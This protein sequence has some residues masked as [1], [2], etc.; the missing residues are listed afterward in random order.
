M[1]VLEEFAKVGIDGVSIGSNDLTMLTLGVDRDNEKIAKD[2]NEM[3][4]AVL[5]MLEQTIKKCQKLKLTS[6]ICG[7]APSD[8]P[9]FAE[10]L[11][12]CGIDSISL[13]PD[14]VAKGCQQ[15][16]KAEKKRE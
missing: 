16:A 15:V 11:V 13:N 2:F 5:W 9:E 7:Q 1:V 10:F 3:D 8:H 4:P 12:N 14:S 6:S